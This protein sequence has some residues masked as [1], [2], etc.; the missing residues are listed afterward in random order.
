MRRLYIDYLG[1]SVEIP[2]GETL[3]GR[4]VGCA[5]RFNDATVSRRHLRFVRRHD[6]DFVEDLASSNGSLLN[7]RKLSGPTRVRDGDALHLGNRILTIRISEG[8]GIEDEPT[9]LVLANVPVVPAAPAGGDAA[10]ARTTRFASVTAPPDMIQRCPQC[11][12]V[13]SEVDDECAAC[14]YRWGSFRPMVPTDVIANPLHRRRHDR[15]AVD[16]HVLYVSNE[17]E[18]EARTRDLSRSGVFVCSQVLDPVG[19]PCDLT[20]LIDGG[21]P[22]KVS[23]IVRRVVEHHESIRD[24]VGLGVE[25]TRLGDPERAW[26]DA[27]V[28]RMDASDD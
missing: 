27:I 17:L 14:H 3:V 12:A 25:F 26:I 20:I 13:V 4:D 19:T 6:E 15:H 18:I 23:G 28:E 21:P 8:E 1:D 22:I 24:A 9:T 5:L 10:R 11:G 7:A 16:L 2:W